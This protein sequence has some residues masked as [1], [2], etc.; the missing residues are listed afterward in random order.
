MAVATWVL[1]FMFLDVLVANVGDARRRA[2]RAT[3][4]YGQCSRTRARERYFFL[5]FPAGRLAL[6]RRW[7]R[8]GLDD[9]AR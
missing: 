5:S 3:A 8:P 7:E 1:L 4:P 2:R 9:P 6:R